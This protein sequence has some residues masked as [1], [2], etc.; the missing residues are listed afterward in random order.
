MADILLLWANVVN[1]MMPINK[2]YKQDTVV[3]K[4][5]EIFLFFSDDLK[6]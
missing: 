3:I 2:K 5:M 1:N 6:F 4:L